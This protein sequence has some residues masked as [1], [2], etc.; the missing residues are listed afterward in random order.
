MKVK[1]THRP[2]F[3]VGDW[4]S[5]PFAVETVFAQIIEDRGPLGFKGRP[6][7][8]IRLD[9]TWAEPDMF[10]MPEDELEAVPPPGKAAIMKFLKEGGLVALLQAN[11]IRGENQPRAWLSYTRTGGLTHTLSRQRGVLGGAAVPY[12]ALIED[13]VYTPKLDQ[14]LDFLASFGLNRDEA[15]E[16]VEVVGTAPECSAS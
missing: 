9:L 2:R 13:K 7:Y 1:K 3:K 6:M 15:K 11:L 12:F 8:R 10:E 14:V 16:V 4:V 5:F